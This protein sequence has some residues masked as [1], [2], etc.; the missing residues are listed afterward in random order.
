MWHINVTLTPPS[1]PWEIAD[2]GY[3][4]LLLFSTEADDEI[5]FNPDDIIHNIE[6]IDEG[7]WKGQCHGLTG[8]FPA[9][10]VQLIKWA[11]RSS[12]IFLH[13]LHLNI[14]IKSYFSFF[15]QK[16]E[17]CIQWLNHIFNLWFVYV[18]FNVV[19]ENANLIRSQTAQL[20]WADVTWPCI[21][22]LLL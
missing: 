17:T 22:T 11:T 16:E 2:R 9:A 10:Y 7:W 14:I 12:S 18:A 20:Q 5:S 13:K 21:C 1:T 19:A 15:Q 8:L 6:M 4:G 3:F